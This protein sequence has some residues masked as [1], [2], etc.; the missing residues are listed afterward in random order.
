MTT[1]IIVVGIDG[2]TNSVDALKWALQEAALRGDTVRA[3][4]CWTYP[5]GY[6]IDMAGVPALAP[7]QLEEGARA[8][9]AET[10]AQATAGMDPAPEVEQIVRHGSAA[11]EM[12]TESK[13]ADLVVVGAR[14]HG[15]FVGLLLGSV[16]TQVV[17]HGHCPV[18]VV[19]HRS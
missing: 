10:V 5:V 14:G 6:G 4:H 7:E 1:R 3:L 9:L 2:S 13:E 11:N 12:V 17:H 15:G 16:A 19:P 18:V 8:V